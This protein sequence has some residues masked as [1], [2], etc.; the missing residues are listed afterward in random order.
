MLKKKANSALFRWV[1]IP[2]VGIDWIESPVSIVVGLISPVKGL[3]PLPIDTAIFFR[4]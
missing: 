4:E 2:L 3:Y 1:S